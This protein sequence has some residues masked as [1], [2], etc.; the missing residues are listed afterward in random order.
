MDKAEGEKIV[1][2]QFVGYHAE[3]HLCC[4]CNRKNGGDAL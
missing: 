4:G 3:K 1:R 2:S